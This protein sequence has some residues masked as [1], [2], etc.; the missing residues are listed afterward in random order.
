M[1][2]SSSELTMAF[3]GKPWEF[4]LCLFKPSI[5]PWATVSCDW[6]S[7][8]VHSAIWLTGSWAPESFFLAELIKV[9]SKKKSFIQMLDWENSPHFAKPTLVSPRKET[10]V[11]ILYWWRVTIKVW[12]ALLIG[13]SP[14]GT[15]NQRHGHQYG[16]SAQVSQ[17]SFRGETSA[18]C[19][20]MSAVFLGCRNVS[21]IRLKKL[22]IQ[23]MLQISFNPSQVTNWVKLLCSKKNTRLQLVVP[24][25]IWTFWRHFYG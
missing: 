1:T 22:V 15:T 10:T 19:R 13:W 9:Q 12:V 21:K 3:S 18:D 25:E 17:T 23:S 6:V 14:R 8:A 24:P 16:I 5:S 7:A 4:R 11:E 2:S 20:E